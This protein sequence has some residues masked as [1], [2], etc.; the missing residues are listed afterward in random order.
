MATIRSQLALGDGM[1]PI[2]RRVTRALDTVLSD[3]GE[4][5]GAMG[6]S[7][8]DTALRSMRA[9]LEG[10]GAAVRDL[11]R[12][13]SDS[14]DRQDRLNRSFERG[15]T[16]AGSLLS[17]VRGLAASY[18]GFKT[19]RELSSLSDELVSNEARL[20]LIVDDGGSV[21]ALKKKIYA[22][23]KD[24]RASYTDTMT[25]VAKLGLTA[26]DAFSGNDE[27]LRFSELVNKNLVIGGATAAEQAS[28]VYQLTQALSSGRLQGDE[29]RSI[30]ENAPL[31]AKSIEAYMRELRGAEGTMKDWAA[32]GLLT[33]DVIKAAVFRSADEVEERFR[34]MPVTWSQVWTG[35]KNAGILALDPL[36]RKLGALAGDPRAQSFLNGLLRGFSAL[37]ALG[38]ASLDLIANGFFKMQ[39]AAAPVVEWLLS[40]ARRISEHWNRVSGV[41]AA[42]AAGLALLAAVFLVYKAAMTVATVAQN[43]YNGALLACPLTWILLIVIAVIAAVYGIV[44][45]VNKATGSTVSATGMI[46]GALAV[47]GA[48]IWDLFLGLLDIA[49]GII[50]KIAN[51]FVAFANFF[52]NLFN[53][54]VGSVI[55]LFADMA[56]AVLATLQKL[57]SAMDFIFGSDMAGTVGDW[58]DGLS[59][60]ADIKAKEFG[61]GQ[62]EKLLSGVDLSVDDLGLK[63]IEYSDAWKA[64]YEVGEDMENGIANFDLASILGGSRETLDEYGYGQDALGQI[65]DNTSVMADSLSSADEDL[66]YLR[67]IAETEAINRFTTAEVKI[68]M[69]GMQNRIDSDMDL[70]GVLSALTDGFAEALAVAA[71]GAHR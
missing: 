45:A 23:A 18:A 67:D 70:D 51:K 38:S 2:L 59:A 3:L 58:R 24:A 20:K 52:G 35:M 43:I 22:S 47:A 56:D 36:L 32:E 15:G 61:N 26:G 55:H 28:A 27:M 40:G 64:G 42:V 8:D 57:A 63:R 44:A 37:A 68:D 41:I 16:L 69:S 11:E 62:Y 54:P 12:E 19:V 1:T 30:I 14:G 53:D 31:L 7:F 29:Y 5:Q 13:L 9:S 6:E 66:A 10:T 49:F 48:F 46:M 34:S 17:R 65:A 21:E 25:T 50:N 4:L 60:M 33:S 39:E 71:E